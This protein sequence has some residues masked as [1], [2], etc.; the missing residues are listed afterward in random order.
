[1]RHRACL[2]LMV[3]MG[4]V[5]IA[6]SAVAFDG[7]RKGLVLGGG[8]GFAPTAKISHHGESETNAGVAAHLVIGYAWDNENMI[9]YEGNVTT[10]SIDFGYGH[11][12]TSSQGFN[13]A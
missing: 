3:F 7:Q 2:L 12:Y 11:D 1:M 10:Y 5:L 4:V 9:V 8:L 6:G 13:G